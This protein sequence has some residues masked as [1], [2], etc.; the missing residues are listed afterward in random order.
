MNKNI[1]K[2]AIPNIISNLTVPLLSSVDTALMGHMENVYYLGAIAV[3][4]MIFNFIYWGFGFL[5]MGTTGLTAQAYGK[6]NDRESIFIL[7]RALIVALI[8]S[9]IL[10]ICR[11]FI[12]NFSFL[13]FDASPEVEQ[14][15]RIYFSIRIMAAPAI[16]SLYAFTGWFL[17]MQNAKYLLDFLIYY[18]Q[19][20]QT[21]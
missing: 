10:I 7:S 19:K 20:S 9:L 8:L 15:G 17:G 2:L 21:C 18:V 5:R 6:R 16:L 1:L 14:Y 13:L 12:V 3:G 4:G 11:E